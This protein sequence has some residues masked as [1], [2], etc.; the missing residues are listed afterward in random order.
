MSEEIRIVSLEL[1][2]YR[3]YYGKHKINFSSREEGFTV[4]FGKNGE[5][6]SNLLNA[7]SWC[8]YRE[9]P[10]GMGNDEIS[11]KSQNKSLPII[12][13]RYIRE[14]EEEQ[15][16][17]TSVKILIKKGN[18]HYSISRVLSVLKHK[19]EY[20]EL[21]DGKKSLQITDYADDKVPRGCEIMNNMG[22][23]VVKK[24]G[25]HDSDF[26]DTVKFAHPDTMIKEILPRNLSKYFLLDGEFLE[27]F[28]KDSDIIQKGVEQISQLHLLSSLI[29]HI[30]KVRLPKKGISK[31]TD[32][33]TSKIQKLAWYVDSLDGDGNEKFSDESRWKE[34]P[35]E[36]DIYYH[37][38]GKP[39]IKDLKQDIRKMQDRVKKISMQISNVSIPSVKALK[40]RYDELEKKYD[41][42]NVLKNELGKIYRYNLVTQSPY[43]FLKKA[44]EDSINIIETRIDL[45]DL[46]IRQRRQFADDLL[47]RKSCVCGENLESKIVDDHETNERRNNILKFKNSLTGKDDL[48]TAVD[49]R[50]DFTHE[51][52]EKY[53]TFLKS[54]FAD[55][56]VKFTNLEKSC[57]TLSIELKGVTTQLESSGDDET[58]KLIEE[59][60][61]ILQQITEKNEDI[62]KIERDLVS[63][64]REQGELKI[65]WKRES[66]KNT[67]AKKSAH[68][69]KIWDELHDYATKIYAQLKD[70]IRLDVQNK[71]WSNFKELLANSSEFV[72]FKIE[73]DYS[74]YLIDTHDMNKIRD[75][76]AGQSLI[77]TLAFVA[78]LRT[79]TGYKFPLVVDSPLGK[80][81][82]GNRQ[83]IAKRLPKY[84]PN[85]QLTLL[86]TDTEYTAKL[87]L[88]SDYPD[89]STLPFGKIL[90]DEI[91]L[92][93]LKISK[94]KSGEN[95]GNSTIKPAKLIYDDDK[96]GYVVTT[97]V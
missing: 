91:T 20:K 95:N 9:E 37:A 90:E 63:N 92:K 48:D 58:A 22:G 59:Q 54:N 75:L 35:D 5:G 71:T 34:D 81:D 74:A 82:S 15:I 19:L 21:S 53:D 83:N 8:L 38:T 96:Q 24:K 30:E 36:L 80:I 57:N 94:I 31:D 39:R 18:D 76:S 69:I 6:K 14:L 23:F 93:H 17:T 47:T 45:G 40:I 97:D 11:H 41:D 42:E 77:L 13:N 44:I 78:A 49:M 64:I 16:A 60:V 46:P 33:I 32:N 86:V 66:K 61:Y 12:N 65:L 43:V 2:N 25:Q 68:E 10:H 50:Y 52:I 56:R 62:I 1:E 28:W 7:I 87:P 84:F 4:I 89:M 79:P 27:G 73:E 85:E 29:S 67:K 3:P 72:T 26:H 70:E 51:F 88:D 55:P